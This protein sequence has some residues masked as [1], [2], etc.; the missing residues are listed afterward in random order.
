MNEGQLRSAESAYAQAIVHVTRAIGCLTEA[1]EAL[2]KAEL[3][4][5]HEIKI[6]VAHAHGRALA[7]RRQTLDLSLRAI[8][9][10][11]PSGS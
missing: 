5:K 8:Q 1:Q 6:G 7:N 9:K 3:G 11:T 10:I 4:E 2:D